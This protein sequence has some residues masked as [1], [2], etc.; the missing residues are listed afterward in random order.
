MPDGQRILSGSRDKVWLLDGTLVKTIF[1][2]ADDTVR[3]LLALPDNQ[4]A[5]S[6]SFA[7]SSSSTSTTAPSCAPSRTT[8]TNAL[9]KLPGAAARRPPLRQRSYDCSHRRARA[10]ARPLDVARNQG[11]ARGAEEF[12]R[13]FI[14]RATSGASVRQAVARSSLAPREEKSRAALTLTRRRPPVGE[15]AGCAG[16]PWPP[17][18]ALARGAAG[19]A[20]STITARPT[21]TG[22]PS[23][24]TICADVT[25]RR[26]RALVDLRREAQRASRPYDTARRSA[27]ASSGAPS[28]GWAAAISAAEELA[29]AAR[30]HE[31]T[32]LFTFTPWTAKTRWVRP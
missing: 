18:P 24:S 10:R 26:R 1:G 4:H 8:T 32:A 16:E 13:H 6:A 19:T 23:S 27:C 21:A 15:R 17:P 3:V 29:A 5:L 14:K 28:S 20:R 2:A 22:S 30:S 11:N 9:C 12:R 25:R 31:E 7:T